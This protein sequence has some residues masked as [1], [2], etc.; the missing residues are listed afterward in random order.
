M[1]I[2][3]EA[4][5]TTSARDVHEGLGSV[6]TWKRKCLFVFQKKKKSEIDHQVARWIIELVPTNIS[7]ANSDLN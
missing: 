3:N 2:D 7:N 1:S 4:A 5:V 6:K